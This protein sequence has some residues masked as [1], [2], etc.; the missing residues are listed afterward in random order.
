MKIKIAQLKESKQDVKTYVLT[1]NSSVMRYDLLNQDLENKY[2]KDQAETGQL[3]VQHLTDFLKEFLEEYNHLLNEADQELL[4]KDPQKYQCDGSDFKS[5]LLLICKNMQKFTK[6]VIMIDEVD[7]SL[8]CNLSTEGFKKDVNADFSY[9]AEYENIHFI[10]CLRPLVLKSK[11][12]TDF[13]ILFPKEQKNQ[14]YQFFKI[15]HRSNIQIHNFLHFL[16][17]NF[18]HAL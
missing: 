10:L 2:L 4:K 5:I 7:M 1:F 18:P 11:M 9:L 3:K 13:E 12:K 15:R 8:A 17:E 6:C 14:C 16:Q